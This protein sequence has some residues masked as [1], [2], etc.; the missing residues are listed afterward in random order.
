[1]RPCGVE[2]GPR[3]ASR[4]RIGRRP[5]AP[6]GV[7]DTDTDGFRREFVAKVIVVDPYASEPPACRDAQAD[8]VWAAKD[9]L[10]HAIEATRVSYAPPV[11]TQC[12]RRLGRG[13]S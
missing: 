6:V 7:W 2:R 8:Y 10:D 4:R 11:L 3:L 13:A 5:A 9:E 1:M 12:E